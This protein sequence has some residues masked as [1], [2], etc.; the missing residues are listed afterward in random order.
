[1]PL[2]TCKR[3]EE[4][5][6]VGVMCAGIQRKKR[7]I[8]LSMY[9][10]MYICIYIYIY[11]HIYIYI[12]ICIYIY[13]YVHI[14]IYIYIYIYNIYICIYM[15]IYINIYIYVH[16]HICIYMIKCT[17][18]GCS[19]SGQGAKAVVIRAAKK[20]GGIHSI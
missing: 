18:T 10:Y 14:C 5:C 15:Y 11:I 20:G 6:L 12:N 8:C 1:M 4:L 3:C 13:I 17:Y 2:G 7:N 9:I 19:S 16:V